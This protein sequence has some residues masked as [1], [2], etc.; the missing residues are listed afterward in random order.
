MA[1]QDF[2][3]KPDPFNL[4]FL[5]WWYYLFTALFWSHTREN[6]HIN[7]TLQH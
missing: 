2:P 4:A 7:H 3:P 5:K 1:K 6:L